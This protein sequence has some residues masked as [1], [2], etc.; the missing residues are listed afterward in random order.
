MTAALL[1]H[2]W[3]STLVAG[4]AALLALSLRNNSARVR[5]WL[6][7]AASFK[8][9][10][11]F[12]A[13]AALGE[14]LAALLP[15]TVTASPR[16]LATLPVAETIS[17]PAT[18][19]A[20]VPQATAGI[21]IALALGVIWLLGF[22]AV[23]GI[24]LI[25][26]LHLR[27]VLKNARDI[28]LSQ[29][30]SFVKVKTSSSLLEPGL[31]GIF[32][33]VVLLPQGL[34]AR[35]SHGEIQSILA[36]ELTHLRRRDNLTAAIH[37]WVEALFWFYPL[38]WLIGARLIAERER[39]CDEGVLAH[40]H[41]R[42]VYAGGILK[43]CKFCLQSPLA[44]ASG[45]SGGDLGTRVRQIMTA[46]DALAVPAP[47]KMLL[48][49]AALLILTVPVMAGL[50]TAPLPAAIQDV[51]RSVAA[52]ADSA[53]ARG[54]AALGALPQPL[55]TLEMA[56]VA[57]P[58]AEPPRFTVAAWQ[59][60]DAPAV[61]ALPRQPSSVPVAALPVLV[62]SATAPV[63]N[64]VRASAN[65]VWA[66]TPRGEGNPESITCRTPQLLP[67]SR[68]RGPAVCQPNKVWAQFAA[69]HQVVLPDGKTVVATGFK[70]EACGAARQV[71]ISVMTASMPGNSGRTS[72]NCSN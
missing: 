19:L 12:A 60:Q 1:D 54:L 50:V 65:T 68:L 33:P 11:P 66:T 2:L 26:S 52:V 15:V 51:S 32:N 45:V 62:K 53:L 70:S 42:E 16:L 25:R 72:Y 13:L 24:R 46:P 17:A 49:G 9:L 58:V 36:H 47:K 67:G 10:I 44:C 41:D 56:K 14:R 7:F 22:V 6:W 71:G 21:N 55:P 38:V 28:D 20:A 30:P 3:Q 69:N 64:A 59:P 8:F 61:V 40:G 37:M 57:A 27:S 31:V 4:L 34:M 35:L 18:M 43:V 23:L 48:A 5:F 39:A 29:V 63:I